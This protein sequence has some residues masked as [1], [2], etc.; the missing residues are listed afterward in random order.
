MVPRGVRGGM[1]G[2]WK[3]GGEMAKPRFGAPRQQTYAE[4][5]YQ[6]ELL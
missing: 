2:A 4:V 6:A 5:L 3:L 1:G